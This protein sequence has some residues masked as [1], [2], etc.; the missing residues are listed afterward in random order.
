[1]PNGKDIREEDI[2][3]LMAR[4]IG[5]T[6]KGAGTAILGGLGSI[7]AGPAML[8]RLIGI[9][10]TA[11][12]FTRQRGEAQRIG[13]QAIEQIKPFF[14]GEDPLQMTP[15]PPVFSLRRRKH[16]PNRSRSIG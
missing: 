16:N 15:H 10:S 12:P 4:G 13:E 14:Q 6:A 7:A 5:A 8:A 3:G 1:M 11:R 9:A 2:L